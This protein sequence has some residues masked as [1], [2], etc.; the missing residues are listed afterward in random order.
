MN[1]IKLKSVK[2]CQWASRE[3]LCFTASVYFDGKRIAT[4]ENDGRGGM[5]HFRPLPEKFDQLQEAY[6]WAK[7]LPPVETDMTDPL[8]PTRQFIY[9]QSLEN[10]I[11]CMV[12]E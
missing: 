11:D 2:V 4:A 7:A 8:D 6:A 9:N 12:N 1:R 10:L 5:T 3:T